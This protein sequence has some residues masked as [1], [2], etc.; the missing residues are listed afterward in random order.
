M[1]AGLR[2]LPVNDQGQVAYLRLLH[3][4]GHNKAL[5]KSGLMGHTQPAAAAGERGWN[6][7][8]GNEVADRIGRMLRS[9]YGS[10]EHAFRV[11]LDV[12]T[13]P[14][15]SWLR[16]EMHSRLCT[17]EVEASSEG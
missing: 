13:A 3:G 17:R 4:G 6:G 7:V 16:Y 9:R 8:C 12:R 15:T 2:R 10:V 5:K 11:V 14:L 1:E